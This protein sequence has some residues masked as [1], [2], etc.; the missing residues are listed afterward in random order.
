MKQLPEI[1]T[2]TTFWG[3]IATLWAASGAWFTYVAAVI[4]SRQKTYEG[5]QNVIQGL[6]AEFVLLSD[7]ASGEE[8]SQ[9]YLQKTRLQL[10]KEHPDWFNPSRMIFK[11]STPRL[12]NITTSPYIGYLGPVVRQLVML[13]HLTRQLLDSMERYQVFV[14]GNVLMY[15]TVMEKFAPKTSPLELAS[16]TMPTVIKS[17]QP[18]QVEWTHEERAYIN[19]IFMMNEAI[20]QS[21][22]GGAESGDACLYKSFRI[23][24]KALHDFKQGLKREPIPVEFKIGHFVAGLLAWVGLWEMMR[25][26]EIW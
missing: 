4:A 7:W 24:R 3:Y 15:Q 14:M 9:G 6:E 25:W 8:G 18:A 11:F 20:H 12:N 5:I 1:L 26:F 2:S 21:V 10:V 16:S 17:P 22:I 19:I 13:N 23:A